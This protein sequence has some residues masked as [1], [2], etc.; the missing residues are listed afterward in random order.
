MQTTIVHLNTNIWRGIFE[1]K[2]LHFGKHQK[3]PTI[4]IFSKSWFG[5]ENPQFTRNQNLKNQ[6]QSIESI[7]GFHQVKFLPEFFRKTSFRVV[8]FD[9]PTALAR[10]QVLD[11]RFVAST[12]SPHMA[13]LPPI[14]SSFCSAVPVKLWG[15]TIYLVSQ[16]GSY[17]NW[18]LVSKDLFI[19]L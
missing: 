1:I 2:I 7:I 16:S 12:N 4:G 10:G 5:I 9:S 11:M 17:L 19:K 18:N 13:A 15:S 8:S 14:T 6:R 3:I